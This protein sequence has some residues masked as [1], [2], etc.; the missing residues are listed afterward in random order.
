MHICY[1][2]I[3]SFQR[4]AIFDE[5]PTFRA[6]E[7]PS[8]KLSSIIQGILIEVKLNENYNIYEQF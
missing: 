1:N 5:I 6:I 8:T 7:K 4:Y 3:F 2:N